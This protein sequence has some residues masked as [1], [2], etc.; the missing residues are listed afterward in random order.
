M[1]ALPLL[2]ALAVTAEPPAAPEPAAAAAVAE[3]E[4]PQIVVAPPEQPAPPDAPVP[5]SYKVDGFLDRGQLVS[6]VALRGGYSSFGLATG[7]DATFRKRGFVLGATVGATQKPGAGEGDKSGLRTM[8]F[9]GGYGCQRG[10]YRG[11]ALL[12]W[13]VSSERIKASG[14]TDTR[15]GHFTLVQA[16]VDR[17]LAGG[18]GWRASLGVVGWYRSISSSAY[19]GFG[20]KDSEGGAAVRLGVE[21]GW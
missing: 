3:E 11:E 8:G 12:G 14:G 17:A 10:H 20:K 7:V 4:G 21:A 15:N 16:G 5:V 6:G 13:G 19:P 2:L 9:L 18:D 1:L